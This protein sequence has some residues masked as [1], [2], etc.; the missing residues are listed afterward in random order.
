MI[1]N[2]KLPVAFFALLSLAAV[3][4]NSQGTPAQNLTNTD[5]IQKSTENP[6]DD[7][8]VTIDLDNDGNVDFEFSYEDLAT[9]DIPASAGSTQ[10]LLVAINPNVNL[11]LNGEDGYF[12]KS[13]QIDYDLDWELFS[14]GYIASHS[15]TLENGADPEWS[16]PWAGAEN[17][18]IAVTLQQNGLTHFGWVE[19]SVDIATGDVTLH[20]QHLNPVAEAVAFTGEKA[21]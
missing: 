6:V 4:C 19:I 1:K 9:T 7:S 18:Y 12:E 10:L 2:S 13:V 14:R 21:Q 5:E 16:G 17:K 3:G 20:D 11:A 8:K 15:W